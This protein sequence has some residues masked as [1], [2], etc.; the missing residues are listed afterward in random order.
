MP[1]LQE[2]QSD[3]FDPFYAN[4][5][6]S[7]GISSA[8]RQSSAAAV[9]TNS[10]PSNG[11]SGSARTVSHLP[12]ESRSSASVIEELPADLSITSPFDIFN[13]AM[14]E[15]QKCSAS[16]STNA[17]KSSNRSVSK[18]SQSASCETSLQQQTTSLVLKRVNNTLDYLPSLPL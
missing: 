8:L 9:D 15:M 10:G 2:T 13:E 12:A 18:T 4:H 3:G 1:T 7:G 5:R 6:Y 16:T 11:V 17:V 14:E